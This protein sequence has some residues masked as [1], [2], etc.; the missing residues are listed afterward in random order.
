MNHFENRVRSVVEHNLFGMTSKDLSET[1]MFSHV[2]AKANVS[3]WQ[4]TAQKTAAI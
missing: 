2:N 1:L 4:I 3:M